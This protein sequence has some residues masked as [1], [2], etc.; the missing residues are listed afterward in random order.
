MEIGNLDRTGQVT[1][2][3]MECLSILVHTLKD[4]SCWWDENTS[5]M[6]MTFNKGEIRH[7]S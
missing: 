7:L 6:K 3:Y 4:E 5:G 2:S 1:A